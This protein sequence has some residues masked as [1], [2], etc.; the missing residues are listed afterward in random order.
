MVQVIRMVGKAKV[1]FPKINQM[2]EK[3][4][5]LTLAEIVRLKEKGR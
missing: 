5:N 2:A 4:G 3:A 1:V